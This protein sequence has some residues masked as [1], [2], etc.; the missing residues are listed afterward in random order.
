MLMAPTN[1]RKCWV[2]SYNEMQ[3][4]ACIVEAESGG[5]L[6]WTSK[7]LYKIVVNWVKAALKYL[8]WG[9]TTTNMTI[10]LKKATE[11][12]MDLGR[13]WSRKMCC[14][15]YLFNLRLS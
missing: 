10:I 15:Q 13:S 3:Y 8:R 12:E 7:L 11:Y 9:W 14:F 6:Q 2:Q 1:P 4:D 5:K